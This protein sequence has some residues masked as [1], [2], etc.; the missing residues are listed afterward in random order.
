MSDKPQ[1]PRTPLE[2]ATTDE[3][4]AEIVRRHRTTIVAGV[5]LDGD[6]HTIFAGGGAIE[7][8][9]LAEHI[10]RWIETKT[11]RLTAPNKEQQ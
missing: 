6:C 4:V 2:W 8:T 5:G 1:E 9:G 10:R 11:R 7:L 3:L